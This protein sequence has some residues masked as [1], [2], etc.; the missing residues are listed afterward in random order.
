MWLQTQT[1]ALRQT[2]E[3]TAFMERG[4]GL[5]HSC[6]MCKKSNFNATNYNLHKNK[7]FGIISPI[8]NWQWQ[9]NY[10][11]YYVYVA[12]MNR[13]FFST[14]KKGFSEIP[15]DFPSCYMMIKSSINR[16]LSFDFNSIMRL[17]R[18]ACVCVC[19]CVCVR[20]RVIILVRGVQYDDVWW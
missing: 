1:S 9:N 5:Q 16:S 18:R 20:E 6:W 8:I 10:C 11:I 15:D 7:A 3:L 13:C 12:R 17:N 14:G 2:K 4:R 19:V